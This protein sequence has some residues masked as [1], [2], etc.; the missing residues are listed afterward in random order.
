MRNEE[1][2]PMIVEFHSIM[3]MVWDIWKG[4]AIGSHL[5]CIG[6]HPKCQKRRN[7]RLVVSIA[8][9]K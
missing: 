4:I 9:K 5:V 1:A 7:R 8:V 3:G 2:Y 6:C